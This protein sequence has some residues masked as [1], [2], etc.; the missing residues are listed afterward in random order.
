[1]DH[2]A[3]SSHPLKKKLIA[4]TVEVVCKYGLRHDIV[5]K[6]RSSHYR[7]GFQPDPHYGGYLETD[8]HAQQRAGGVAT[9][10]YPGIKRLP[11][12]Q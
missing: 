7:E 8:Q 10:D 11:A 3:P 6:L 4:H 5:V 1:M 9:V 2:I 12:A